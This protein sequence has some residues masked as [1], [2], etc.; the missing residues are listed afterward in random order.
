MHA[1]VREY[2]PK[3]AATPETATM[4]IS[5]RS[6]CSSEYVWPGTTK[7]EL[8]MKQAA[9]LNPGIGHNIGLQSTQ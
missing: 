7:C 6:W 1:V 5:V 9:A 8:A 2:Q 4:V 3:M